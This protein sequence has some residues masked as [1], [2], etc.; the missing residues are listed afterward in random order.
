M[1]KLGERRFGKG[2]TTHAANATNLGVSFQLR[3][4]FFK[5][6]HSVCGTGS[7]LTLK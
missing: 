3:S 6:R 1:T 2:S 5:M 4:G 7:T